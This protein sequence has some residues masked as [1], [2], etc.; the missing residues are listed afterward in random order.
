MNKVENKEEIAKRYDFLAREYDEGYQSGVKVKI[1][2]EIIFATLKSIVSGRKCKILDAGG[3]TGFYS[4][5]MALKDHEVFILDISGEMLRE[6]REKGKMHKVS[7]RIVTIRSDMENICFL[8][9]NFDVVLCHLAFSHLSN[10]IGALSEFNRVLKKEGIL[11]LVVENKAFFSVFEAFKGDIQ[12]ALKRLK[13]K[14]LI[15]SIG[16]LPKI[17]AF[18]KQEL[19][20]MCS[21]AGFKTIKVIGLEI[22]TNYLQLC[23]KE[24][25]KESEELARLEKELAEA[26]GW[27]SVGKFLF[28]ICKKAAQSARKNALKKRIKP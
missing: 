10:P 21:A 9:E 20:N 24:P 18:E 7:D 16:S 5:P 8:G 13:S 15:V 2:N 25:I 14:E 26:E 28:L 23:C 12:E 17:R 22:L 6:A 19:I 11:S 3:G 4:V 27:N 1:R